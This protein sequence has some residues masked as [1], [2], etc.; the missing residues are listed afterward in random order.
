M[1]E[2][3]PMC[4]LTAEKLLVVCVN[5]CHKKNGSIERETMNVCPDCKSDNVV[6]VYNEEDTDY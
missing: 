6:Y 3:C 5:E 2:K 1:K 4:G